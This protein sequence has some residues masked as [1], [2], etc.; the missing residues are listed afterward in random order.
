MSNDADTD[1][2]E[3]FDDYLTIAE[4]AKTLRLNQQTVRNMDDRGE[5][6]A[7]RVGHRR[8]RVLRSD[9]DAFL[10]SQTDQAAELPPARRDSINE[11]F[12]DMQDQIRGCAPAS[13]RSSETNTNSLPDGLSAPPAREMRN[14]AGGA[15]CPKRRS[16]GFAAGPK[17]CLANHPDYP[18]SARWPRN[19]IGHSETRRTG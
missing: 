1:P 5:L 8:V 18:L 2:V 17:R 10:S 7:V 4:I 3:V 16:A 14:C 9:L 19:P 6:R 15:D 11:R 13:N 12:A